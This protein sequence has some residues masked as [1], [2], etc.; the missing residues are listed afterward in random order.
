MK[1]LYK[2]VFFSSFCLYWKLNYPWTFVCLFTLVY[3]FFCLLFVINFSTVCIDSGCFLFKFDFSDTQHQD[4][5]NQ[6]TIRQDREQKAYGMNCL[7]YF[8]LFFYS[9]HF[10]SISFKWLLALFSVLRIELFLLF[11]SIY[12]INI[13]IYYI[14]W[15]HLPIII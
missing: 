8:D 12:Y 1:T 2:I 11:N 4:Y 6:R 5:H 10:L 3:I 14:N 7:S 15:L 9:F 13:C